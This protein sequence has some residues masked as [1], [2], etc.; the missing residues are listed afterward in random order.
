MTQLNEERPIR[1]LGVTRRQLLEE[2]DRPALKPLPSEPYEFCRM[3]DAPRRHRLPRR[4]RGAL[5]QRALSL[6]P[7]RGRGAADRRAPSRSSSR[8][9]GSPRIMRIERQSQAHDRADHMPSSHRRYADWTIE[10]IRARR[11]R[12]RPGDGGAL[13]ADPGAPP[14][15]RTGLPRLSRHRAPGCARSAPSVSKRQRRA[16]SRSARDLRLGATP[17]STTSS[18]GTPRNSAPADGAPILHPN[19]RGPR[20][21]H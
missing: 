16:P 6:R 2:L 21:Y 3:A 13:R 20:Y 19:I 17:S 12:D 9:S 15:S 8:A 1:R 7:R 14:A 11:R 10:R 18:I 4:G 5:L